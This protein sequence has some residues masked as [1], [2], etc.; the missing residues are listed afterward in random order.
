VVSIRT[1]LVL[2][3]HGGL[4]AQ[5]G[6]LFKLAL[7]GKLGDGSQFMPWISL[8]DEVRAIE[9]ALDEDL[10]TGPVNLTAPSPV[11]NAEFTQA[12]GRAVHRPAPWLVPKVALRAALGEAADQMALA[13][14]RAVPAALRRAG[15][16]FTHDE[17]DG[18]LADVL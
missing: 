9:F 12:L 6:P 10:L 13:G 11:T 1:G 15:F 18:A 2:S 5:L 14:Q 7:G 4:L 17:I 3:A 8:H 16:A